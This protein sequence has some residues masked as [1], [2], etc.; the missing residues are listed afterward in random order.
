[1]AIDETRPADGEVGDHR[2]L[3][4]VAKVDHADHIGG[5]SRSTQ[6]IAPVPVVVDDLALCA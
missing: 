2:G 1:M 3:G 4:D 5:V 6:E